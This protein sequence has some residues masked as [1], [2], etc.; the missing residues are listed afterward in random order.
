[1]LKLRSGL[2]ANLPAHAAEGEPLITTDTQEMY[3]GTGPATPPKKIS[4]IVISETT[5]GVADRMKL[6]VQPSTNVTYVYVRNT[7]E[8]VNKNVSTDFGTF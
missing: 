7:W 5:P 2:K 4:D 8:V 1:M 6:W 3:I